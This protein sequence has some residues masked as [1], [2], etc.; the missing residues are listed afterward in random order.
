MTENASPSPNALK[1]EDWAGE[2]GARWLANLDRFEGMLAPIGQALLDR[3]DFVPGQRVLDIGSGGG[4]TTLAIANAVA[5]DGIALGI[6]ISPDLV[7]A[8]MRRAE[9]AGMRN[10]SFLRADASTVTFDTPPFDRLF[11]R[12]GSMFFEQ[13]VAAFSHLRSLLKGGA[14][15]D[16]AV[17]G[18]PRE[19]AWMME[20]MGVLRA[21]V[22]VAQ[23]VPRAPGPF[24]FEDLDYLNEVLLGA[25]FTGIEIDAYEGL[26]PIGG[27]A[28]GAA[29]GGGRFAARAP[30]ALLGGRG[31]LRG[32]IAWT[33]GV[34][35]GEAESGLIAEHDHAGFVFAV[36]VH[37][38]TAVFKAGV[39][40]VGTTFVGFVQRAQKRADMVVHMRV[41]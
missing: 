25:G 28:G 40:H 27:E 24:A 4:T 13:P 23:A 6:D 26:Q 21:N 1:P 38:Q 7:G 36:L 31:F 32:L 39:V 30:A 12:F 17:W 37:G 10:A 34:A 35:A 8:A 19:N 5:P 20:M 2:M 16:L 29:R 33:E 3:A 22:E 11:S 15:V 14:G 9:A 18:P 41:S